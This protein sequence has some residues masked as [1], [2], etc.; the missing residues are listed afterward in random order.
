MYSVDALDCALSLPR[1][2]GLFTG[3]AYLGA[4]ND[5]AAATSVPAP[6]GCAV[7]TSRAD[8]Q[9]GSAAVLGQSCVVIRLPWRVV[10]TMPDTPVA[11]PPS[12]V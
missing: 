1:S 2:V 8:L 7:A 9:G 10:S 6:D 12:Q 4:I 5:S 11:P 3:P